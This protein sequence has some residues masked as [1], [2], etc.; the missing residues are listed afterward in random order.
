MIWRLLAK[1]GIKRRLDPITLIAGDGMI[2]RLLTEGT[3]TR[4]DTQSM[5]LDISHPEGLDFVVLD[6]PQYRAMERELAMFKRY[7]SHR[8]QV[9]IKNRADNEERLRRL[10]Q[11][12]GTQ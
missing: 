10:E 7:M 9:R 2:W 12:G 8:W 4:L 11:L 1:I 5:K 3:L 6:E